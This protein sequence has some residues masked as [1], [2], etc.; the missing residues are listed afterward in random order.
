MSIAV[1]NAIAPAAI[2]IAIVA[3]IA[4]GRASK[5]TADA[6][7]ASRRMAASLAPDI[8]RLA[9]YEAAEKGFRTPP[10]PGAVAPDATALLDA[11][12]IPPPSQSQ[13]SADDPGE[14][15]ITRR[16]SLRW[17][18]IGT[19]TALSAVSAL[20]TASPPWRMARLVVEP[21]PEEGLS[22]LEI[23]AVQPVE[24]RR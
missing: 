6:D 9:A 5:Q 2:A 24:S 7:A 16:A 3:T 4:A 1:K 22:R 18:S 19:E 23:L 15:W 17:E 21:L 8:R 11:A 14:G 12:G 10:S 20:S 13:F